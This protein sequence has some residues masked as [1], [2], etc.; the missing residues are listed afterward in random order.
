MWKRSAIAIAVA[1]AL[2]AGVAWAQ[3]VSL[4]PGPMQQRANTLCLPCHDPRIIVQQKLDRKGW[5]KNVDKMIRWGTPVTAEEKEALIDYLAASFPPPAEAGAQLAAGAGVEKVRA[6]CLGCHNAEVIT[7]L[8]LDRRGW[9]SVVERQIRY[10][11]KVSAQERE[12][13]LRYLSAQYGPSRTA[14]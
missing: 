6:A 4:P 12:A 2:A 9:T 14:R 7:P 1:A 11:A 8:R 3:R 13:I 10:G 5:A